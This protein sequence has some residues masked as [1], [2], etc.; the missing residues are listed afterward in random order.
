MLSEVLRRLVCVLSKPGRAVCGSGR[1]VR[2]LGPQIHM[3][4]LR[5]IPPSATARAVCEWPR[6]SLK[7]PA[8]GAHARRRSVV[9]SVAFESAAHGR[10]RHP[11]LT[12]AASL[13]P[14]AARR[15]PS[16]ARARA[17]QVPQAPHCCKMSSGTR[18][19]Q[20]PPQNVPCPGNMRVP[21]AMPS[22]QKVKPRTDDATFDMHGVGCSMWIGV[23]HGVGVV[24]VART[25]GCS[26]RHPITNHPT[27]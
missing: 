7:R 22:V 26:A 4:L 25:S 18:S 23:R 15:L 9:P 1:E 8:R 11:L 20:I 21:T 12:A 16:P 13:P 5:R 6:S 24:V 17:P 3:G 19:P 10:Q 27:Q 14:R 2:R